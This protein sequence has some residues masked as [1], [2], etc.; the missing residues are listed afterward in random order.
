MAEKSTR[1]SWINVS[2]KEKYLIAQL[3]QGKLE[4]WLKTEQPSFAAVAVKVTQETGI[5]VN[6]QTIIRLCEDTGIKWEHSYA[7]AS[8]SSKITEQVSVLMEQLQKLKQSLE[9]CLKC[10]Q[11]QINLLETR[12]PALEKQVAGLLLDFSQLQCAAEAQYTN[13]REEVNTGHATQLRILA[14]LSTHGI[15][16]SDDVPF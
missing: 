12:L 3:L 13:L 6:Q 16:T 14:A 10:C 4:E 2:F 15:D 1:L 9:D 11:G 5:V 7:S 8:Q